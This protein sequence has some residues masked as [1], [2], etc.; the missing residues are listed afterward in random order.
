L[1]RGRIMV[2]DREGLEEL[3][4]GVYGV[5]EAEYRRLTGWR[6]KSPR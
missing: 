5:P 2:L 4:N 3:G 6:G 1:E